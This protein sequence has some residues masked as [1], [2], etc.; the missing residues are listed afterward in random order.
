MLDLFGIGPAR[1]ETFLLVLVRT[2]VMLGLVPLFSS[3]QIPMLT[4]FGLGLLIAFA[5]SR[6]IPEV[7]RIDGVGPLV[8]AILSQAFVALVFGF[9][10][11][12]V[13]T[14]I[15]F[16]GEIMD[17]QVGFGAVNIVNPMTQQQVTII[18]Q[19]QLVLATLLFLIGDGHHL[20]LMGLRGSFDLIPLPFVRLDAILASTVGMFFAQALG[21]VF[22]IAAPVAVALFIT[23]VALGFLARVAPQ[24]N[25]FAVGFPLQIAIGLIMVVVSL[26][27][28][29]YVL[30]HAYGEIP[31]H[32]DATLRQMAPNR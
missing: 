27:L 32:L 11:S 6:T 26:P 20:L 3:K 28:L 23:N 7:S 31:Q 18:G 22:E 4:R 25:V 15:Q 5:V 21:L 24:M 9:V 12:L 16:A 19:F 29:G 17:L 2:S 30:P 1:F 14:G 8:V 10:A 13:F